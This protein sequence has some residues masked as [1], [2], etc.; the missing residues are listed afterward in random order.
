MTDLSDT[1]V[2]TRVWAAV[3]ACAASASIPVPRVPA[4]DYSEGWERCGDYQIRFEKTQRERN[5]QR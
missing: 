4:D 2:P 5:E 1:S 3:R